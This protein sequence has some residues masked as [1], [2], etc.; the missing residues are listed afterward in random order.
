MKKL[1]TLLTIGILFLTSCDNPH[2]RKHHTV[3]NVHSYRQH[4]SDDTWLYWYILMN[5]SGSNY[6]YYSSPAPVSSYSNVNWSQSATN[7][8]AN[9]PAESVENLQDVQV[10]E[11]EMS[12]EM[13]T[14]FD[15]TPENFGGM[16][17]EEMG[18]YEG[19]QTTETN[20]ESSSESSGSSDDGGSSGGDSGGDSGGGDGGGGE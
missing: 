5:N 1:F 8:I 13:Q 12:T 16:T 19:T 3:F 18:D 7:P 4:Q 17:S 9:V 6:Y 14:T 2:E 10:A 20:S 15:E 11:N